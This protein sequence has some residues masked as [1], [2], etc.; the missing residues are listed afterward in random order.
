MKGNKEGGVV[1][2]GKMRWMNKESRWR[3]QSG[4]GKVWSSSSSSS[5]SSSN[6]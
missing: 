6:C 5:S 4:S 1:L 3:Y 2:G